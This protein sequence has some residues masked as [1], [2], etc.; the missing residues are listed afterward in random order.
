MTETNETMDQ[1]TNQTNKT[2]DQKTNLPNETSDQKTNQTNETRRTETNETLIESPTTSGEAAGITHPTAGNMPSASSEACPTPR[3]WPR[4]GETDETASTPCRWSS[5]WAADGATGEAGRVRHCCVQRGVEPTLARLEVVE[6]SR[7]RFETGQKNAVYVTDGVEFSIIGLILAVSVAGLA[8]KKSIECIRDGLNQLK[9]QVTSIISGLSAIDSEAVKSDFRCIKYE[10]KKLKAKVKSIDVSASTPG[11]DPSVLQ[12]LRNEIA[13]AKG[14][15]EDA[16]ATAD[17][18][19]KE[20]GAAKD[21]APEAVQAAVPI[22]VL[23]SEGVDSGLIKKDLRCIKYE[24][25]KLKWKAKETVISVV[26]EVVSPAERATDLSPE[27]K[28]RIDPSVISELREEI[29]AAKESA[30]VAKAALDEAKEAVDATQITALDTKS[31]VSEDVPGVVD[32]ESIK[33]DL[34]CIRYE[35]KKLESREVSE[36]VSS[37]DPSILQEIRDEIAAPKATADEAKKDSADAKDAASD[38]ERNVTSTQ[39][40][41]SDAQEAIRSVISE[42]RKEIGAAKASAD[43]AKAAA[44][45]AKAAYL[46]PVEAPTQERLMS[47]TTTDVVISKPATGPKFMGNGEEGLNEM[48]AAT[49]LDI[50]EFPE[51]NQCHLQPIPF[52]L[53]HQLVDLKKLLHMLNLRWR[54]HHQQPRTPPSSEA[55]AV[56]GARSAVSSWMCPPRQAAALVLVGSFATRELNY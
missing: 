42:L 37:F 2:R 20:S 1:K 7:K 19:K 53:T 13:W 6:E 55:S 35:L 3:R 28:D 17:E 14:A 29:G 44:D 41:V 51:R 36:A 48:A 15:A 47:E 27:S 11:V 4:D 43:A 54:Q 49:E 8:I 30:D 24:M 23:V 18:A 46:V 32:S 38:A 21:A 31:A 50:P 33:K 40:A 39:D 25:K 9:A 56:A 5:R 52:W 22:G 16:K 12:E 10:A 26:P 45:E 34:R